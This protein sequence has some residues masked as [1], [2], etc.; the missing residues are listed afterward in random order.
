MATQSALVR[1]STERRTEK[2]DV[3]VSAS[4]KAKLQAAASS[5]QRS[6]SEFV[7]ESAL[8]RADEVLADRRTFDLSAEAWTA[9]VNALDAPAKVL[10]R[11]RQ[12]LQEQSV[13]DAGL[14]SESIG[15]QVRA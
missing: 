7:L 11:M 1:R 5:S 6:L 15:R 14:P 12:L 10:P 3:R 9:F 4:V 2:L 8:S 13:F